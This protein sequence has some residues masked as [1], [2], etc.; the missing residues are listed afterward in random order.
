MIKPTWWAEISSYSDD[1]CEDSGSIGC[2]FTIDE[3]EGKFFD[4][5]E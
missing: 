2:D 5:L 1:P 4:S 3:V